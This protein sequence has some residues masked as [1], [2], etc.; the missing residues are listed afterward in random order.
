MLFTFFSTES[1]LLLHYNN[2]FH[3]E[4][5]YCSKYLIH[6]LFRSLPMKVHRWHRYSLAVAKYKAVFP[7]R[8]YLEKFTKSLVKEKTND[9]LY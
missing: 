5:Y 4:L 7:Q 6:Y 8:L 1:K 9:C 3:I 2:F